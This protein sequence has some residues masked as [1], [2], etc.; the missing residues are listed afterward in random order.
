MLLR[1]IK[2]HPA[3]CNGAKLIIKR[4]NKF[5]LLAEFLTGDS[6]GELIAL[7]RIPLCPS[8]GIYPF[9]MTR[10]QFPVRLAFAMTINKSQGQ[11]LKR[12]GVY[13]PEPVFAHGQLYVTLS[14]VGSPNHISVHLRNFGITNQV[15]NDGA[16][17]VNAVFKFDMDDDEE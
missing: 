3:A 9:Q 12:V 14:R 15:T 6:E 17:T 1:N 7:S 10:L 11:T 13:L 4:V 8:D 5:S 16:C 2:G